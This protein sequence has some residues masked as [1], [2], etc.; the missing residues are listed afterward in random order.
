MDTICS[1]IK[2]MHLPQFDDVILCCDP[3][4]TN[5]FLVMFYIHCVALDAM[6]CSFF[7][8]GLKLI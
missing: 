8:L 2:R 3:D 7:P 4:V 1:L 6:S 5:N